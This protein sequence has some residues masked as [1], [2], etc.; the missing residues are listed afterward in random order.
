MRPSA[1]CSTVTASGGEVEVRLGDVG[2][3]VDPEGPGVKRHVV[4]GGGEIS[5]SRA[6]PP[7]TGS[8]EVPG[9]RTFSMDV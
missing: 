3:G 4:C 2:R 5:M 7:A 8:G 9:L 6:A 1:V